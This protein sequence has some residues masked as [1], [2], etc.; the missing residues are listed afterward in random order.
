MER[1]SQR[2]SFTNISTSNVHLKYD[3]RIDSEA[4]L[5]IIESEETENYIV[6]IGDK[7]SVRSHQPP[8]DTF[9]PSPS[10]NENNQQNVGPA[11]L[12]ETISP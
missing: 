2:E 8:Y 4:I 6:R 10:S 3:S 11:V 7:V 1:P 5:P 9:Y 12:Q